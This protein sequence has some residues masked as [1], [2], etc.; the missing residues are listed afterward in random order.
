MPDNKPIEHYLR[1]GIFSEQGFFESNKDKYDVVVINA[2]LASY[3]GPATATLLSGMLKDKKYIVDPVTHAFGHNPRYIMT[4]DEK[5]KVKTSIETLASYYGPP[6]TTSLANQ[7]NP[8]AVNERDFPTISEISRLAERVIRFQEKFLIESI[9]ADDL[10][11]FD[12]DLKTILKPY[13]FI[14]PYF[15]MESSTIDRWLDINSGLV[16]ESK[17]IVGTNKL[18]AE[19]VIDRG[20]LDDKIAISRIVDAYIGPNAC[21]GFLIWISD[22]S[23]HEAASSTLQG[24]K[25][26]VVE[27]G[28]TGKPIINL[29]GGYF[30]LLLTKLGIT[31]V[32]HGP[33]YGEDRDVIPV[34]GG[35]PT[36]KFYLTPIHQRMLY[37]HVEIMVRTPVW[38]TINDFYREVCAGQA[39]KTTLEGDLSN[40]YR[41]GQE[42]ISQKGERTYSFPTTDARYRTTQHYLEAKSQ[43]FNDVGSA[44]NLNVLIEQL[45]AAKSKYEQYLTGA[46]LRY[47]DTWVSVLKS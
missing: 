20:I 38:P 18:Y 8:R 43:E 12:V 40:F 15:Y 17:R 29:F 32:C 24:L 33:G 22:L 13:F 4:D 3:F 34:G 26:L 2:N 31:G 44:A 45:I 39:C 10:K 46:Q 30:S 6:I 5:P 7:P 9:P 25:Q 1:L 21:D 27:L 37:R 16:S 35:L 42:K 41:F 23:E 14:A 11:Y 47:L 36:S 28:K 19:I